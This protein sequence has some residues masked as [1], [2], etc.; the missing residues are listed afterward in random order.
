[1]IAKSNDP[2]KRDDSVD[3]AL[4]REITCRA[5]ELYEQHDRTAAGAAFNL[6]AELPRVIYALSQIQQY[7]NGEMGDTRVVRAAR[8][9]MRALVSSIR[10]A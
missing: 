1:M 4:H 10:C 6:Q 2:T 7:S 8:V 5:Y 3:I 9:Y